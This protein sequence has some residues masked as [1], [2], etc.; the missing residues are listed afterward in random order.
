MNFL[1]EEVEIEVVFQ[2][3]PSGNSTETAWEESRAASRDWEGLG[4]NLERG[5]GPDRGEGDEV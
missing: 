4:L 5:G 3:D 1:S 2:P